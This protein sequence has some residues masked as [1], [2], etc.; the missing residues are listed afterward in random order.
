MKRIFQ[1]LAT[2]AIAAVLGGCAHPISLSGN[3][4]GVVGSGKGKIDKAAGLH[5]PPALIAAESIGPGGGGDKVSYFAYRDLEAGLY[6]AMSETF[7]KVSRVSSPTD[8]K[9]A[10]DGLSYVLTPTVSATSYSPSLFTWPPTVFTID[11][12][13]RIDDPQGKQV[14]EVGVQGEGR[15]EFDEF[16][17][18]PSLAAKRA[19][20]DL[21][22]KFV[23]ALD[24]VKA[25]LR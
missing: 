17:S 9:I 24:A 22:K 12:K 18:D 15:A 4:S 2:L 8:P 6:V 20:E 19:A 13:A 7:G 10:A 23:S 21:L 11:L 16:K 1:C 14:A 5:I 25:R 3:L